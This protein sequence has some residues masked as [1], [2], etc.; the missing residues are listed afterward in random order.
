MLVPAVAGLYFL[1]TPFSL[2]LSTGAQAP[3]GLTLS[4]SA[5]GSI[6][7]AAD[8]GQRRQRAWPDGGTCDDRATL[9]WCVGVDTCRGLINHAITVAPRGPAGPRPC[10]GQLGWRGIR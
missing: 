3:V 10:S 7:A 1:L 2:L 5:T 6:G 4:M 8:A 9:R